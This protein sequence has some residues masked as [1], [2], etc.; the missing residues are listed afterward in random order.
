MSAVRR[1]P[2]CA[3]LT[4]GLCM[5]SL[6]VGHAQSKQN[7]LVVGVANQL[8]D[9]RWQDRRIGFGLTSLIAEALFDSDR[10]VLLEEKEEI[11]EQL[12]TVR[13]KLWMLSEEAVQLAEAAKAAQQIGAEWM[14]YGRV[15]SFRTPSNRISMG[16]FHSRE[17]ITE[18][19]VEV[20]LRDLQ[21]GRTLSGDGKGKAKTTATSV[22][23]EYRQDREEINFDKTTVGQATKEAVAQAVK[24]VLE[25][26][27]R[28]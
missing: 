19:K 3:I 13:E 9:E 10:F 24:K 6:S 5:L 7:L 18:I 27:G 16:P 17:K 28:E 14:A 23:F 1:G 21:S 26:Y 12:R 15:V 22:V 4:L 20:N 25:E 2:L 11:R 8:K